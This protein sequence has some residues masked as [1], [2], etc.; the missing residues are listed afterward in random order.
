MTFKIVWISSI[1]FSFSFIVCGFHEDTINSFVVHMIISDLWDIK[2]FIFSQGITYYLLSEWKI[3]ESTIWLS[4]KELPLDSY[5]CVSSALVIPNPTLDFSEPLNVSSHRAP[6][7]EFC[8][9]SNTLCSLTRQA[10]P[11]TDAKKKIALVMAHW[12]ARAT[13]RTQLLLP[14]C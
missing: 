1:F 6:S 11:V 10:Y 14:V 2:Q 7:L 3:C 12:R 4:W 9:H 8:S 5:N 13:H